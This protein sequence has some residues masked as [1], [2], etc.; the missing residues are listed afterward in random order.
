MGTNSYTTKYKLQICPWEYMRQ[1]SH[2]CFYPPKEVTQEE[3]DQY[4]ATNKKYH[5]GTYNKDYELYRN[6]KEE[7]LVR[8]E[9]CE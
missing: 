9:R 7:W 8:Y 3:L 6:E 1:Y 2:F 5:V 4:L